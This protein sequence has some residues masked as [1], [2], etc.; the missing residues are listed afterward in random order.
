MLQG[1]ETGERGP[2]S[3]ADAI[4]STWLAGSEPVRV[5]TTSS[6]NIRYRVLDRLA[7]QFLFAEHVA[8]EV[9]FCALRYARR[10]ALLE[11]VARAAH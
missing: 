10:Y 9:F 3:P 1:E 4:S 8:Q 5:L 7:W 11:Q 6:M 2:T